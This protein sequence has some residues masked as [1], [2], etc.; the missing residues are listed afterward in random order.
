ME[1][2]QQQ[3]KSLYQLNKP[4]KFENRNPVVLVTALPPYLRIFFDRLRAW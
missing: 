1:K 2:T 4:I 3:K